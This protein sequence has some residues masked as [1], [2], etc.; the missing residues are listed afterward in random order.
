MTSEGPSPLPPLKNPS[1]EYSVRSSQE[2]FRGG[3]FTVVSDEVSMPDGG[4]AT[5]DVLR[6]P[7][8]V[9][10]VP[11]D[12]E[13]KVL[14]I[15]QYRHA[16]GR[17]LWELPAGLLD[18]PGEDPQLAGEREL[19]EEAGLRGARWRQLCEFYPSP[20]YSNELVRVFLAQDLTELP[21]D[22]RR[23]RRYEE[24]DLTY[25]WVSLAEAVGMVTSRLIVNGSAVVGLLAA[26]ADQ[27][28]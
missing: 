19:A 6:H 23:A 24:F 27:L 16:V 21:A 17:P 11:L 14:L 18:V 13:K 10:V 9:V 28:A 2:R 5:R 8:A 22:E 7:G 12:A 20:G 25:R 4:T 15:G 3:I 26:F 1:H